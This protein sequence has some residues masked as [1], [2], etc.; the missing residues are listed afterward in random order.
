MNEIMYIYCLVCRDVQVKSNILDWQAMQKSFNE[1]VILL[2]REIDIVP[3]I[4]DLDTLKA[5]YC[6]SHSFYQVCAG[7]FTNTIKAVDVVPVAFH[8]RRESP[9]PEI[10]KI[11]SK[12]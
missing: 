11:S 2:Q 12:A 7:I 8:S 1:L 5:I 6:I 3:D 10:C 4:I 9:H